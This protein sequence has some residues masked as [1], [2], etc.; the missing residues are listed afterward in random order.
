MKASH[1]WES[2]LSILIN[3]EGFFRNLLDHQAMDCNFVIGMEEV[4]RSGGISAGWF[5]NLV[6]GRSCLTW[7]RESNYQKRGEPSKDFH[8]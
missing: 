8:E 3:S 4:R 5:S 1:Q 6:S 2:N 7:S